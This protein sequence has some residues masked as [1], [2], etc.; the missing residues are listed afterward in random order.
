MFRGENVR[1][2]TANT[3][4]INNEL[5]T[6]WDEYDA[7]DL[8]PRSLLS[9]GSFLV[10]PRPDSSHPLDNT[11]VEDPAADP[12]SAD[13]P[14]PAPAAPPAAIIPAPA[15]APAITPDA[16]AALLAGNP[17]LAAALTAARAAA[18]Q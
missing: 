3:K 4:K 1:N 18:G 11:P 16:L 13:P 5:R 7:G 17:A 10:C 15:P 6:L 9:A 8:V 12:A 2:Q 14:A